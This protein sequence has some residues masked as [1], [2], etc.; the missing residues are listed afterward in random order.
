MMVSEIKDY[1][2][3]ARQAAVICPGYFKPAKLPSLPCRINTPP[4]RGIDEIGWFTLR[5]GFEGQSRAPGG[6]VRAGVEERA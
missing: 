5:R 4:Q 6:F 2:R 1:R 3:R